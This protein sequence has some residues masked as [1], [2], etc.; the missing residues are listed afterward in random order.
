MYTNVTYIINCV[1]CRS[2]ITANI[3]IHTYIHF[4][5]IVSDVS[6]NVLLVASWIPVIAELISS[7]L[8]IINM[9]LFIQ[10]RRGIKIAIITCV[11]SIITYHYS[12]VQ[13]R[14]STRLRFCGL[15]RVC[16]SSATSNTIHIR[17][18]TSFYKITIFLVL[19]ASNL[20]EIKLRQT[21]NYF[22]GYV[23]QGPPS[24]N[25]GKRH[26]SPPQLFLTASSLMSAALSSA[27]RSCSDCFALSCKLVESTS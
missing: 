25:S 22:I 13:R 17:A 6:R 3:C 21:A 4:G 19:Q 26:S 12:I 23:S 1:F 8:T 11:F 27:H 2:V 5:K 16:D 20:R 10:Y 24:K 15:Q 7:F 9:L 14:T 18:G